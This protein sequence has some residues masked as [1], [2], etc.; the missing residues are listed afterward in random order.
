V[1]RSAKVQS[2]VGVNVADNGQLNLTPENVTRRTTIKAGKRDTVTTI[3]KRYRV[4][5][6]QV[7]EWNE[8]GAHAA[9]AAGQQVVLFLPVKSGS[10]ARASSG[11]KKRAAASG[12]AKGKSK[13]AARK[14]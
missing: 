10:K 3:A 2:D 5:A 8:V 9:F 7:A 14:R 4:T 6:S 13:P 12:S 11:G 1:P